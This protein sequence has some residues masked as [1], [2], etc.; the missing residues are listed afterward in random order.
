MAIMIPENVEAF[1]TEGEKRFY[2]F[3]ASVAKPDRDYMTWYLPDLQGKEPDFIFYSD[4][5]GLV[6]FEVKD[7]ALD[8]IQEA[9]PHSFNLQ[10]GSRTESRKN[11]L[12]Q[13]QDYKGSA[14]DIIKFIFK[15]ISEP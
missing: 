7:W 3:L 13:A 5:V 10:I 4:E 12:Q 14:M 9:N 1:K 2:N 8:Q 15:T 6:I 11:P